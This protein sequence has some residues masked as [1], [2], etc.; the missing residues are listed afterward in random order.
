MGTGDNTKGIAQTK[1]PWSDQYFPVVR[2][3]DRGEAIITQTKRYFMPWKRSA[4]ST[5]IIAKSA[6][7]LA[8]KQYESNNNFHLCQRLA[9]DCKA[10]APR[11][12]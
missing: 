3:G 2:L 5:A 7:I 4:K 11:L 1:L 6:A 9:T 10:P 8:L 12:R